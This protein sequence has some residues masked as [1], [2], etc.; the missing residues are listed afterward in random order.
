MSKILLTI[1][2]FLGMVASASGFYCGNRVVSPGDS[3]LQVL[4]NCGPPALEETA[5]IDTDGDRLV[6]VEIW[7]YDLGSGRLPRI[8]TFRQGRLIKITVGQ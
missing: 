8:L 7:Y 6:P 5:R 1:A 4:Q 2:F 3:K